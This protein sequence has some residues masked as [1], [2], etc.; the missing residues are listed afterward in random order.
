MREENKKYLKSYLL[1]ESKIRRLKE[2][3]L[4]FPERK[5]EYDKQIRNCKKTRLQIEEKINCIE[6]EILRE[7]LFRKYILGN[8]LEEISF[9]LNYSKRQIERLHIKALENLHL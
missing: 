2:S 6:N 4:K 7:I 9:N 8:T 3:T 5:S 1:Q